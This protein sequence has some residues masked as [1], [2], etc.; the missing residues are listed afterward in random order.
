MKSAPIFMRMQNPLIPNQH[1]PRR[2]VPAEIT[3][4]HLD[5]I[6]A[7]RVAS[8]TALL[9]ATTRY[10]IAPVSSENDKIRPELTGNATFVISIDGEFRITSDSGSYPSRPAPVSIRSV[11]TIEY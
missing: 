3:A 9:S 5:E 4:S 11:Q 1:Q 6:N 7:F 2:V 10:L 8:T